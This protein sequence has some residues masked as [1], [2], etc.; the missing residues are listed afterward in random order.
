M[1]TFPTDST[2]SIAIAKL[3]V[4]VG[5]DVPLQV[6][7]GN[8]I[9][10]FRVLEYRVWYRL[11]SGDVTVHRFSDARE[12]MATYDDMATPCCFIHVVAV[13]ESLHFENANMCGEA[14]THS[15]TVY[16][17]AVDYVSRGTTLVSEWPIEWLMCDPI[18]P[19]PK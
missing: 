13:V 5:M 10:E 16:G 11:G 3:P 2:R 6:A 8:G 9:G 14:A 7:V 12:A 1:T 4:G 18:I 19:L 17:K 15:A